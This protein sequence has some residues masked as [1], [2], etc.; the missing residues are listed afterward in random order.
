MK[1]IQIC[2]FPGKNWDILYDTRTGELYQ[3]NDNTYKAIHHLY[4]GKCYYTSRS[5]MSGNGYITDSYISV[6]GT[7]NPYHM[8]DGKI[9]KLSVYRATH[10]HYSKNK[11]FVITD[12]DHV[13]SCY[14]SDLQK[15]IAGFDENKN[16]DTLKIRL[17]F[18]IPH[19]EGFIRNQKIVHYRKLTDKG[20]NII[21]FIDTRE[22]MPCEGYET[23]WIRYGKYLID[24]SENIILIESD[25]VGV[26]NGLLDL[27][28]P[29]VENT[30]IA[31]DISDGL[32][33]LVE[34][35]DNYIL[36]TFLK[37]IDGK[38]FNFRHTVPLHEYAAFN[39]NRDSWDGLLQEAQQKLEE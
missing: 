13:V 39:N 38:V 7:Y 31:A 1:K 24:P 22:F 19:N 33:R 30:N 26:F 27:N 17:N 35:I 14:M 4:G 36:I 34:I 29:T 8:D 18:Y 16:K 20:I 2:W 32:I 6:L 10:Y 5:G 9:G 15:E 21:K 23:R 37:V 11:P 25:V 12:G 28:G 3:Y